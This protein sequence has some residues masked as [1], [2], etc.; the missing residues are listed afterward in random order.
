MKIDRKLIL[1]LLF[2]PSAQ[3]FTTL[4]GPLNKS[5]KIRQM[6]AA[7]EEYFNVEAIASKYGMYF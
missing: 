4:L 3:P 2:T 7:A 5:L 6:S 1:V